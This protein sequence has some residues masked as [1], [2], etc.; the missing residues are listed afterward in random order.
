MDFNKVVEILKKNGYQGQSNLSDFWFENSTELKKILKKYDPCIYQTFELQVRWKSEIGIACQ[1]SIRSYIET[2]VLQRR[3]I[4]E[5][6]YDN[7]SVLMQKAIIDFSNF[8]FK[9]NGSEYSIKDFVSKFDTSQITGLIDLQGIDLSG[10]SLINCKISNCFFANAN[11]SKA[12]FQQVEMINCNF[13][14]AC[15]ENARLAMVIMDQSSTLSSAN[16]SNAI[17]NTVVLSDRNF[18]NITYRKTSCLKLIIK[19][20]SKIFHFKQ[21][22][23]IWPN[24]KM[25]YT[26]FQFVYTD[27]LQSLDNKQLKR[28]IDWFMFVNKSI[29]RF[30]TLSL[31]EKS[32]LLLNTILTKY[33]TSVK[34]LL[35]N[36]LIVIIVFSI[37]FYYNMPDLILHDEIANNYLTSLYYSVATFATFGYGDIIPKTNCM[38][39]IVM[40]EII[41][42]YF[43]MG[44]FILLITRNID[45]KF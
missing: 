7:P 14:S 6:N 35:F 44:I 20:F 16:F 8:S 19:L 43:F 42:G 11:F 31:L 37:V 18:S 28:Y 13:V 26:D 12:N 25:S 24:Y 23:Q 3:N 36:T 29:G 21:K 34:T 4:A 38:Q 45:S 22:A 32:D 30:K 33:W 27:K 40:G 41:I 2:T 10:I 39:V 17:L 5:I 15:F 1:S 9:Y